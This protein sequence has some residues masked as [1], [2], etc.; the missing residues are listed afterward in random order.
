[1]STVVSKKHHHIHK[2]SAAGL[3]VTLGIIYGDIGTSPLYVMNAIVGKKQIT[4]ELIMGA[5]S[6]VFWTLTLITTVKYVLVTLM[7]DNK[8]EGG[9]FALF[10]LVR[11]KH[12]Y[13]VW[14]AII[15]GSALL[16]DSIITPPISVSAAIEGLRMTNPHIETVPIV[17][18]I[19]IVLFFVQRFGTKFMGNSFGPIMTIWFVML[20]VLGTTQIIGN[21][22][23]LKAINPYYAFNLLFNYPEGFWLLGS[24]F[25]CTTGVEALYSDLG[26]C[27]RE[28]IRATWG[29]VKISLLLNYFGQGAWL[30]NRGGYLDGVHPFYGIMPQDFLLWGIGI[31]TVATII[32]SQA[33]ISGAFTLINEAIRLNLWP[34]VKIHY[35]TIMKGQI[36]VPSVNW[37][38]LVGCLLVVWIFRESSNMEAAYGLAINLTMLVTTILLYYYLR[39]MKKKNALGVIIFICTFLIIETCFLIAN[40]S[41]FL[42][43]G[44]VTFVISSGLI[45]VMWL[46]FASRKIKNRLTEFVL[47]KDY[48]N[49]LIELSHDMS[50][51]KYATHLVY[52]TS[53]DN[54]K[55]IESKIMYSIF[56]KQPKRADVYWLVHIDV[57]DEP[58]TMEYKVDVIL[59]DDLVRVDFRLGFRVE[60]KINLYFRKV[61]EDMVK[62]KEIDFTSR[63]TSLN[64]RN[65]IGDFKFVVLEKHLSNDNELSPVEQMI[66][67]GHFFLKSISLSEPSAFGL[68]TSS[69]I[70]EKVP[71]VISPKENFEL[72]RI[73]KIKS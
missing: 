66:M 5:L 60:Q 73:D 70:E 18:T 42:H 65:V 19:I 63:Y 6:L 38:L 47:L 35:P 20:A 54:P 46:W 69:V 36:Y 8:G 22:W 17:I 33:M 59:P 14:P 2:L 7:A 49:M 51:P 23:I 37:L 27:G 48:H 3:L 24:V 67:D 11:R 21:W 32:A 34:K 62:N 56:N 58:Y 61:V 68:D 52:L 13:L 44:Y 40:L 12:P 28:N 50:V 45:L 39:Y 64:K 55:H 9:T 15:G 4:E 25:L 53:A 1:M 10:A 57:I 29:F 43:G 72:K 16:A 26:H 31:A 30:I 71:L 41:K